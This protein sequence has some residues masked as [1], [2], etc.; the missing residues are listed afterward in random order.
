VATVDF[1]AT[2]W[3]NTGHGERCTGCGHYATEKMSRRT[4][5]GFSGDERL[6]GLLEGQMIATAYGCCSPLKPPH[7]GNFCWNFKHL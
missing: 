1:V 2:D 6:E 5:T 4:I 7:A 3:E